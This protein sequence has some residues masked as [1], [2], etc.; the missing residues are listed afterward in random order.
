MAK[1]L[2]RYPGNI[3]LA[4][5][6]P[7]TYRKLMREEHINIS[8]VEDYPEEALIDRQSYAA[9]GT[10]SRL[11]I[12]VAVDGKISRIITI[13]QRHESSGLAGRVFIPAALAG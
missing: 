6:Y 5:L 10:A 7:W 12:P 1:A 3:N 13:H 8:R 2:S 4:E 11:A 9:M